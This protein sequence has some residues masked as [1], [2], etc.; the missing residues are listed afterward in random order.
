MAPTDDLTALGLAWARVMPTATIV[1]A[2]G[3]RALPTPARGIL[4]LALAAAIYPAIVPVVVAQRSTPWFLLALEQILLGLPVALAAA[5]PLWAATMAGGLVDVLRGSPEGPGLATV[6]GKPSSFGVLLSLFASVVFLATGGAS[7][8]ASALAHYELPGHPLLAAAHDI[9][10]GVGLAIA[11][12]G[13]LLAATVVL[14]LAFALVARAASP[15]QV[16]ALLAPIRALGLLAIVALVLERL[17]TLVATA[18][19]QPL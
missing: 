8:A 3:L 5:I 16:H 4:G 19:R 18:A 15:A 1:P 10:A 11:L 2:F 17:A 14:E 12:G 9:V 7:R 6:E 13:P